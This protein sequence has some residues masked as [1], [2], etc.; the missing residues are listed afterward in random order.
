MAY[1]SAFEMCGLDSLYSRRE[2]ISLKFAI[3]CTHRKI[4]N[5][6]FPFNTS[7][8][9]H[10]LRRRKNYKVNLAH[11][12][13]YRM[14]TLPYLQRRLNDRDNELEEKRLSGLKGA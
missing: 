14:S 6:M 9:T 13:T 7:T 3:K 11:T 10:N 1:Q 5:F 4:N 2:N 12:E 8:D